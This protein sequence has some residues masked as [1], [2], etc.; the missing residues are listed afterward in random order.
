MYS[1]KDRIGAAMILV[2][3]FVIFRVSPVHTIYDSRYEMLFTQQLIR[4]HSFSL[5][6]RPFLDLQSHQPGQ[7]HHRGV[8]LPYQLI[9]VGERFYYFYPPG[10]TILGIPYVALANAMGIYATDQNGTY[11]PRGEDQM[12]KG[13]AALLMAGLS[14]IIFFTC[15]LVLPFAW[16]GLITAATAFGTQI[17]ST[18][19]RA[20]WSQTWG[21]FVL[22]LIIWLI[23][24]TEAK[25][26]RLPPVLLATCL[27]W[28]YFIR[29][30]FGVSIAA[31]TLYVVYYHREILLRFVLTGC[32]WLAAFIGFSEYHFGQLFPL[33]YHSY[34]TRLPEQFWGRLAGTLISPSRGLFVYVPMLWFVIYLLGRYRSTSRLHLIIL[35]AGVVATHLILIS[36]YLGWHG[37]FC[38]GPRLSTDVVP[39]FALLGIL[40]VEARLR[41]HEENKI[42]DS[43]FRMRTEWSFAILLLVC[44]I[45]LNGIGATW[46]DTQKWNALPLSIDVSQSRLWDWKHPQ[47]LGVPRPATAVQESTR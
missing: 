5:G 17:W 42:H 38:Y 18:A 3:T 25:Q 10:N 44:S 40:A 20:M 47:F 26:V 7:H 27:A 29:P 2:T 37:G 28:L 46:A 43:L 14:V 36:G 32:V 35:A 33:Y 1:Q 19:S 39:W 24:R 4:H 9:Q 8:D 6:P 22:G 12:Q 23:L 34:D 45:T 15:R 16:S 31:I 41:W 21:I 13:L 30:T 11:Y